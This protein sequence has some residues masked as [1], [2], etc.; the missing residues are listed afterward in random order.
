M[1]KL[2]LLHLVNYSVIDVLPLLAS[3]QDH[4]IT[5]AVFGLTKARCTLIQAR[6]TLLGLLYP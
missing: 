2:F 5:F 4:C 1:R 3:L 6:C